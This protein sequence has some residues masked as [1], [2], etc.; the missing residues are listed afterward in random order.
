MR[1]KV[2]DPA[3]FLGPEDRWKALGVAVVK[4][5][6]L[7]WREATMKLAKPD[8]ATKE[9][10]EQK[11]SAEHFLRSPLV[12]FYSGLDGKTLLRKLKEGY[13]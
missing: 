10:N 12:E 7:D 2:N 9:M 1:H 4:Q 3:E 6:I 13:I 8:T 5:A 11:N